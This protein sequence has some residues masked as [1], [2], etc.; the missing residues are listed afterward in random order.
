[1]SFSVPL[2]SLNTTEAPA[3]FEPTLILAFGISQQILSLFL[4]YS[5]AC[6]SA[7]SLKYFGPYSISNTERTKSRLR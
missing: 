2:H 6:Q 3:G 1:M 5:G 7:N 4:I